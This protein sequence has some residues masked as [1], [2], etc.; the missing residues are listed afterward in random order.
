MKYRQRQAGRLENA[1]AA[2]ASP[3]TARTYNRCVR[4]LL[5][6]C[7]LLP[8]AASAE[9]YRCTVEGRTVFTDRPCA[10]NAQPAQLPPLQITED[11]DGGDLAKQHDDRIARQK[12]ARDDADAAFVKQ[13]TEQREREAR[14]RAAIID[15][16]AVPGMTLSQ[17]DSALGS[18]DQE[19]RDGSSHRRI[20]RRA[21]HTVTVRL[22]DG[23]VTHVN[24]SRKKRR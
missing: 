4:P 10:A 13:H 15:H 16:E 19:D 11:F 7:L 5:I 22:E 17:L 9:V 3:G 14:I 23:R 2:P 21:D 18:P 6:L 1:A 24:R 12:K 8:L 20:Y